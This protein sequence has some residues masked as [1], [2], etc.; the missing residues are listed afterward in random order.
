M[1]T[2]DKK[3]YLSYQ[4]KLVDQY[5]NTP[6]HS[7]CKKPI[8]A[9]YSALTEKIETEPKASQFKVND[10]IRITKYKNIFGKSYTENWSRKIFFIAS[11]LKVNPWTYRIKDLN[12]EKVIGIF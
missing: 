11:V 1:T 2:N 8:N 7:I 10:R 12:K 3:S 5:S 9:G 6:Y 4:N